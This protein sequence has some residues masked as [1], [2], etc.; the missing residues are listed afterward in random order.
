ME[1]CLYQRF[2]E[3]EDAHWW[4]VAR[5]AIVLSLLDRYLPAQFQRV[6]L[7]AGCGTGG[8]LKDLERYGKLVAADFSEEAVK[9]CKLRGYEIIQSSVLE[10]PFRADSFDL[11]V[12]LDLLEH[13]DEDLAALRELYRICKPGGF[14]C[15]TVPAFQFLWSHHDELNHHK[16]RYTKHALQ[17]RLRSAR[18]QVLRCSYFNCY[19]FPFM[20]LAR[21]FGRVKGHEQGLELSMPSP[22]INTFLSRVF[23]AELRPLRW[24]DLPVGGSILSIAKKA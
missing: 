20:V 24:I 2:Y 14:L 12:A 19:F 16:R 15:V 7:D 23:G 1:K 8:L 6:V 10:P 17:E 18:F 9:L 4:F 11:I 22:T 13:L 21:V 3:I 5:K